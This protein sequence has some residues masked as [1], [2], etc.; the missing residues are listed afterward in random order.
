LTRIK[1]HKIAI[2]QEIFSVTSDDLSALDGPQIPTIN[3]HLL[4]DSQTY[5]VKS[6]HKVD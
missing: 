2:N 5:E 4:K 3:F 1:N 6:S